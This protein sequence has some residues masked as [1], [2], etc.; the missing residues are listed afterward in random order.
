MMKGKL[1]Q[2]SQCMKFEFFF[3]TLHLLEP[4]H[5]EAFNWFGL[6]A[7]SVSGS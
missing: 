4:E 2:P 7:V 1:K 6:G 5:A 3:V